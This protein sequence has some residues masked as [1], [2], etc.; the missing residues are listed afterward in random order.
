MRYINKML[1][2]ETAGLNNANSKQWEQKLKIP[3]ITY[4]LKNGGSKVN[5]TQPFFRVEA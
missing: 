1:A 4:Y 5:K 3:G 2:N